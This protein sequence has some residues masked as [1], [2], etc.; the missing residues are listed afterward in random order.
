MQNGLKGN[1]LNLEQYAFHINMTSFDLEVTSYY[2]EH[3]NDKQRS[4]I[5]SIKSRNV[6]VKDRLLRYILI[7]NHRNT[8]VFEQYIKNKTG[9]VCITQHSGAFA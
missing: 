9:H 7:A 8:C 5:T 1:C 2:R 6:S 3:R 4:H